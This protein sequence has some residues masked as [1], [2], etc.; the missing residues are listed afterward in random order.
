LELSLFNFL[1][2]IALRLYQL[3]TGVRVVLRR[4]EVGMPFVAFASNWGGV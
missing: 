2:L 3:W 4:Q 1:I